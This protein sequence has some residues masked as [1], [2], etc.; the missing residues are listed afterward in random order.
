MIFQHILVSS[1]LP[2]A[3]KTLASGA[4]GISVSFRLIT[5]EKIDEALPLDFKLLNLDG[6][7]GHYRFRQKYFSPKNV[8]R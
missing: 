8:T 1:W 5:M 3:S 4:G 6:E 2:T 7:T